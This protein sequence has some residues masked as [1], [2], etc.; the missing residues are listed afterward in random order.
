MRA[1]AVEKNGGPETLVVKE[2]AKPIPAAGEVRIRVEAIGVNFID[3]Y[4]RTGMYPRP[5]PFLP[6]NEAAGIVDE[7]GRE[8]TEFAPGERVGFA[9][10]QGSYAEFLVVP[11]AKLV[12][13]P[14]SI[15]SE[16][17][18]AVLLQGMTAHYLSRS[19]FPVKRGNT[20]LVHAGAGGVGLL[21]TQM[22]RE[23]GA[24]VITTV[25]TDHKAQLS[26]EAGAADVILYSQNDFEAEAKR[27]TDNVGVDVVY[28]SVGKTTFVKGFNCLKAR[29]MMVLFGASSGQP[30]PFPPG[31]LGQQGSLFLTRPT[32]HHYVADRQA[33]LERAR[34]VFDLI[35]SGKLRVRIDRKYPLAE[36]AQAHRDLESRKTVGKL[37]LV[38]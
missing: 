29:G 15:P 23:L 28:D 19:T 2:K 27:L 11:A 9:T 33:L 37:I 10:H 38:P 5:L 26:R 6:G 12:P 36:A 3:V 18:A 25:S 20:A 1:I 7:V 35:S 24:S 30:D 31:L 14:A 32:L 13:V 4:Q 22:L 17:A 16:V 8:V 34:E 21:L